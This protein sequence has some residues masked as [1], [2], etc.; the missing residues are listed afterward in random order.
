MWGAFELVRSRIGSNVRALDVPDSIDL[1]RLF[2]LFEG[3]ALNP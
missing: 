2:E 1:G 3:Q